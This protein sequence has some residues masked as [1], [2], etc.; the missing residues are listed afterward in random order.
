MKNVGIFDAK[1]ISL[2]NLDHDPSESHDLFTDSGRFRSIARRLYDI[3]EERAATQMVKLLLY[4]Y[5]E[6]KYKDSDNS[7]ET[8]D[9]V[10]G[11]TMNKWY[12]WLD[13]ETKNL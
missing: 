6:G 13:D 2:Y 4:G 7:Y 1:K 3:L 12:P 9:L 5:G 11:G 8:I 10:N